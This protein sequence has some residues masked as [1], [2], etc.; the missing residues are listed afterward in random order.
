VTPLAVSFYLFDVSKGRRAKLS[1]P[2]TGHHLLSRFFRS[3]YCLSALSPSEMLL[4]TPIFSIYKLE[5]LLSTG[6][7]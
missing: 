3:N 4:W 6:S 2:M 7:I 1:P 5:S